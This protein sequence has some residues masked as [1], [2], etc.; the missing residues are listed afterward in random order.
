MGESVSCFV[1]GL[2]HVASECNFGEQLSDMLRD[3][4]VCGVANERVQRRLLAEPDLTFEKVFS[5]A[6]AMETAERNAS[7]LQTKFTGTGEDNSESKM[8]TETIQQVREGARSKEKAKIECWF[9]EKYGHKESECRLKQKLEKKLLKER[10]KSKKEETESVKELK[11][12][13]RDSFVSYRA[14]DWYVDEDSDGSDI[15]PDCV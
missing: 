13:D 5:L 8:A 9:C 4:L 2:R 7:E 15:P 10:E 1:A 11:Y 3:R 12:D 6:T 14:I